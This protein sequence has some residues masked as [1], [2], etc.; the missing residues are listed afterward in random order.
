[1]PTF[2]QN[3]YFCQPQAI[4]FL[5]ISY[6]CN[7]QTTPLA[8]MRKRNKKS[9]ASTQKVNLI[10]LGKYRLLTLQLIIRQIP[11]VKKIMK[12]YTRKWITDW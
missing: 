9:P 4:S 12:I 3:E 8:E 1:L 5:L 2:Y 11:K 10:F 6:A 7:D